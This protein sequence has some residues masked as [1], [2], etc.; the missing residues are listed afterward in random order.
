MSIQWDGPWYRTSDGWARDSKDFRLGLRPESKKQWRWVCS[1]SR[2]NLDY[3][4]ATGH[5]P[6]FRDA[7]TSAER[8][9]EE[10]IKEHANG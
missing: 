5:E 8:A 4:G 2:T 7:K 9:A 1:P 6:Y 3:D 10:L